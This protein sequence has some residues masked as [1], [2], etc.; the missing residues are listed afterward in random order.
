[1][2]MY[3]EIVVP[4]RGELEMFVDMVF[5]LDASKDVVKCVISNDC[6]VQ[7]LWE[8]ATKVKDDLEDMEKKLLEG[9]IEIEQTSDD[10]LK[11]KVLFYAFATFLFNSLQKF[12]DTP[13][14]H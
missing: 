13:F 14:S 6:F 1:M 3:T 2:K 10:Y 8:E 4:A 5:V 12:C 11:L 7:R 9:K